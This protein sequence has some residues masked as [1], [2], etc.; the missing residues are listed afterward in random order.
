MLS[1]TR[2]SHRQQRWASLPA[3]R[4]GWY[5]LGNGMGEVVAARVNFITPFPISNPN[6]GEGGFCFGDSGN[7]TF[8]I[9]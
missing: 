8:D 6:D 7:N 4:Q 5:C 3:G 2:V 1:K 9:C